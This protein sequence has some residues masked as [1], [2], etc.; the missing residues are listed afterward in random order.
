MHSADDDNER[1]AHTSI[2]YD[3]DNLK[4]IEYLGA[5]NDHCENEQ[6]SR[7]W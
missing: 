5:A 4:R 1:R 3:I 6:M 2:S 7:F